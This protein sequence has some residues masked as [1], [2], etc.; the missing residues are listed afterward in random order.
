MLVCNHSSCLDGEQAVS[1]LVLAYSQQGI[2]TRNSSNILL[3]AACSAAVPS[4]LCMSAGAVTAA[5]RHAEAPFLAL[6]TA[7]L[8]SSHTCRSTERC[9]KHAA[10]SAHLVK[11]I[12]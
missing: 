2:P 12:K 9:L 3:P 5:S 6:N 1:V 10:R 11:P 4:W 8:T 7:C